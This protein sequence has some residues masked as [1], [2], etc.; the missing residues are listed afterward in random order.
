MNVARIYQRKFIKEHL[1]ISKLFFFTDDALKCS[2]TRGLHHF[3]INGITEAKAKDYFQKHH[4]LRYCCYEEM[5]LS[6]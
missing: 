1:I 6:V 2:C 5:L 4:P 3:S